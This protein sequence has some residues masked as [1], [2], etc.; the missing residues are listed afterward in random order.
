MTVAG[1]NPLDA[2]GA[3]ILSLEERV[4]A[5]EAWRETHTAGMVRRNQQV[6]ALEDRTRRERWLR[7]LRR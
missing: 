1:G 6:N 7:T 3:T 4:A 2:L 5:L